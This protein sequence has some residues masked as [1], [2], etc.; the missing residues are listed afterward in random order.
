ML[1]SKHT[2][3]S[4][5][6]EFRPLQVSEEVPGVQSSQWRL[7]S[8]EA[9][10]WCSWPNVL[11]IVSGQVKI[12][13]SLHHWGLSLLEWKVKHLNVGTFW[14]H[15]LQLSLICKVIKQNPAKNNKEL[16]EKMPWEER[17]YIKFCF[18]GF[19][20]EGFNNGMYVI[21]RNYACTEKK[22]WAKNFTSNTI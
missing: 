5:M 15:N 21:T 22:M 9:G 17:Q 7:E 1:S 10:E 6:L 18:V 14:Y 3:Y 4:L 12:F 19:F 11:N 2:K 8:V 16:I 20:S 13:S